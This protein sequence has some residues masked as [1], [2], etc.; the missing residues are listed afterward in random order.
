[1]E[2]TEGAVEAAELEEIAGLMRGNIRPL[3]AGNGGD[4]L[5]GGVPISAASWAAS[6]G[7]SAMAACAR[8]KAWGFCVCVLISAC[9]SR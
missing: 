2:Y 5:V 1:M 9:C 3:S 8:V 7:F 6:F 4:G